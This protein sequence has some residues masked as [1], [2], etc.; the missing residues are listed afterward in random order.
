VYDGAQWAAA[1]NNQALIQNQT[2]QS[3]GTSTQY[4]LIQEAQADGILVT[5][6]GVM[7]TPTVDYTVPGNNDIIEFTTA[8]ALLD[9]IQV[10]FI[11]SVTAVSA[12]V[13]PVYTVADTGNIAGDTG[14][15][16]YVNNGDS[17][18]PCLSVYDGSDWRRIS[19][20]NTIS[21]S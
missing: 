18:A 4:Q 6:N 15:L 12:F 2:I 5:V 19:L 13:L 21:D 11:S 10:R 17:G 8:P 14:Q 3:D 20:G 1:T 9:T 16:I 7:Q